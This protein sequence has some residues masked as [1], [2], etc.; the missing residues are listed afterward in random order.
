MTNSRYTRPLAI[1][2]VV[3]CLAFAIAAFAAWSILE[4]G[5]GGLGYPAL[6][7]R[8]G[9]VC[10]LI[11]SMMFALGL[12]SWRALTGLGDLFVRV[13]VAF[14]LAY[15][16]YAFLVYLAGELRLP[17]RVLTLALLLALPLVFAIRLIFLRLT[18]LAQLKSRVLVLGTG[19]QAKHIQGLERNDRWSRFTVV[20]FIDL[21]KRKPVVDADRIRPMPDDLAAFAREHQVN[22]IVLAL[23]ERRGQTPLAPLISA[24]LSGVEITDYQY[25]CEMAEGRVDL[26]ALRPSWFFDPHGFRSGRL[27]LLLKRTF[28]I[29]LAAALLIFTLPLL[30]VTA[31]A[32]RLESPGTVFFRQERVGKGGRTFVLIKFRS[33]RS[34][35]EAGEPPQWAQESDPR[36]TRL[37][38][39]I[40]KTRIDEIPQVINVLLGDMS[41]VGPRPERPYFVDMLAEHIPF[42]RERHAVRPGITGWA[43]LNYPYGASIEDAKQKLRYD[44]FYIKHFRIVFDLGIVLQT[45]RVVLWPEGAR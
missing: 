19:K 10:A 32:I 27:D 3:E 12:Y 1:L 44:L 36:V 41:F 33:M 38:A 13:L 5:R 31:I 7:L 43:Q 14:F 45:I 8:V 18:G 23:E 30:L 22:E 4:A 28:D 26:D 21:E 40:R 16:F 25:F 34:D 37:G 6:G 20:A 24:R 29:T 15:A 11:A 2:A 39:F 35:A 9:L 42:Y 17:A